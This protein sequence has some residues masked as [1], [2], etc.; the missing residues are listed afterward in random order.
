M[1]EQDIQDYIYYC[2][3]ICD[4][5]ETSTLKTSGAYLLEALCDNI[6]GFTTFVVKFVAA[7]FDRLFNS[8]DGGILE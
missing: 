5:H 6:D 8:A 3:D 1:I 7:V 4:K 2:V